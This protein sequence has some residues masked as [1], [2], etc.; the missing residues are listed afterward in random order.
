MREALTQFTF[1]E[2]EDAYPLW[3]PDTARLV[4]T[5]SREGGGLFWKAADGTGQ[6]E[7][8][9]DGLAR[10]LRMG[11]GR[12]VDLRGRPERSGCSL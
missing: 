12:A 10:G 4:F 5:S 3:T 7:Q 6:V 9:K 11:G 8:L 2:A 1:D